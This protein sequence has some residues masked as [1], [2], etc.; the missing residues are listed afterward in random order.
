MPER[1]DRQVI[2][3]LA[4]VGVLMAFGIDAALPAF[5]DLADEFDLDARGISPAITGTPYLAGMALGQLGCGVLADRFGRRD[6]LVGG[7]V[8]FGLGAVAGA[9]VPPHAWLLG[10]RVVWGLGAA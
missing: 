3:F 2:A 1:R 6:V 4:F 9:A 8:L 10:A 7:L 5:G